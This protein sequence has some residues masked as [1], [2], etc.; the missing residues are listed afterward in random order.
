MD[1]KIDGYAQGLTSERWHRHTVGVK[2]EGLEDQR[3]II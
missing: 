2:K 1:K 3:E